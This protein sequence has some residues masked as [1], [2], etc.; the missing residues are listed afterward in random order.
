MEHLPAPGDHDQQPDQEKGHP[1]ERQRRRRPGV[2]SVD[3]CLAALSALPKLVALGLLSP[4]QA[5]AIRAAY[6]AVL[7]HH[8]Q[9]DGA[10]H[11]RAADQA[12]LRQV[13]RENPQLA[14]FLVGL[15]SDEDIADLLS[16]EDRS[17]P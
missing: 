16:G 12:G 7:R 17:Q 14:N 1:H 13:L 15:L 10:P 6:Q 3:E 5:N 9:Q 2:S 11:R 8:S 4:A